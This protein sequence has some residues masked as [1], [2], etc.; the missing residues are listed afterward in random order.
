MQE[1]GAV[2]KSDHKVHL[3]PTKISLQHNICHVGR[4]IEFHPVVQDL[5]LLHSN[6]HIGPNYDLADSEV[7]KISFLTSQELPLQGDNDII[8]ELYYITR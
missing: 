8:L 2:E 3:I 1:S 4:D 6:T 5:P 7:A